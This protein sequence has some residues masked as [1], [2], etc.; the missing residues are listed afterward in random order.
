MNRPIRLTPVIQNYQ[1]GHTS[2]L[3]DLLHAEPEAYGQRWAELWVGTHP[4]GMSMLEADMQ[5][6]SLEEYIKRDPIGILGPRGSKVREG[7]LPLLLKILA[8]DQ[9]LSIQCHPDLEQAARG[10]AAE[11][12]EGILLD[13]PGRSYKD[14]N[15][16]PELYCALTDSVAMCGFRE[17]EQIESL[18]DSHFPRLGSYLSQEVFSRQSPH[19]RLLELILSQDERLLELY[20]GELGAFETRGLEADLI[21]RFSSLYPKDLS[22]LAPLYLNVFTLKPFEAIYQ[23]AGELHAYVQGVGV[24]VMANSD[25]VLRG[26][27]TVKHV[28]ARGLQE[29]VRFE[30]ADKQKSKAEVDQAGRTLFVTEALEFSL[31]YCKTGSYSV[32]LDGAFELLLQTEGRSTISFTDGG[33]QREFW[34]EP[35]EVYLVPA[36]V[37]SYELKTEGVLFSASVPRYQR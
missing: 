33:T 27:M 17:I 15:H 28:D 23:P 12:A 34:I 5:L 36:S 14:T 2:W 22:T 11:D 19:R 20:E 7:R 1:W 26:G 35:S 29:I 8:I 25:N 30:A 6:M 31:A 3:Q 37:K 9:P 16:K 10:F 18:F 24:E 4:K 32:D 13:D 21:R